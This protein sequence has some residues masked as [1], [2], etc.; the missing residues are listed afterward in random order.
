MTII[1]L[2][3]AFLLYVWITISYIIKKDWPMCFVFACYAG[4]QIGF[5]W[6][7]LIRYTNT[8]NNNNL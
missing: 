4:S 5:I 8:F 2:I 3:L 7:D 6:Q 1:P